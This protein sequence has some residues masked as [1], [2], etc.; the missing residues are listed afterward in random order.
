MNLPKSIRTIL[1]TAKCISFVNGNW[2]YSGFVLFLLCATLEIIL[3]ISQ[4]NSQVS[5]MTSP[6]TPLQTERGARFVR[7]QVPRPFGRGI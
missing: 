3:A 4:N 1:T 2:G 7:G 5:I 6:P